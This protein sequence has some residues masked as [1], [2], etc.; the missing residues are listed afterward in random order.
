MNDQYK[1]TRVTI[2][3]VAKKAGVSLATVSRVIND[4]DSVKKETRDKVESVI[5]S[6]G[7]KPSILAQGL[8]TNK[9]AS[10]A[11]V[12]PSANYVYLSSFLYGIQEIAKQKDL[13]IVLFPTFHS[14]ADARNVIEDMIKSHVDGAI[15]FDDELSS[16]DIK[17]INSYDVPAIIVNHNV[18]SDKSGCITFNHEEV[19]RK[20]TLDNIHHNGKKMKF[21][22]THNCGRLLKRVE[23]VFIDTMERENQPYEIINSDDSYSLS[24]NEFKEHFKF[25]KSGYYIVFRDSI[26]AAIENAAIENGLRIPEDVEILS[27]VGTKYATILRPKITSLFVDFKEVGRKSITM[28]TE[29][30]DNELY[31]KHC[32]FNVEISKQDTTLE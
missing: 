16:E 12:L 13:N 29:L 17:N 6:L 21:V 27:I 19:I 25:N 28:L 22:H 20:I 30:I 32:Q 5:E 4:S 1:K 18:Y 7:Y 3:E 23:N 11:V 8:A 24:Y 2:Y 26:A 10:I 15:V 9:S 31:N 14:K